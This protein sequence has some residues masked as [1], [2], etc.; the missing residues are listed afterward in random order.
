MSGIASAYFVKRFGPM[1]TMIA[2]H[3]PSNILLLSV[4]FMPTAWSAAA[5]LVAR[6]TISQMDVPARQTYVVMVVASDER[7]AAGGITNIVRSLGGSMAPA[8][9]GYLSSRPVGSFA[10]NS[11]WIIAGGVKIAYDTKLTRK[12]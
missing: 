3:L 2:S 6:F 5:M 9:V 1:L 10:F 12:S 8:L 7:S 4:P 11:P